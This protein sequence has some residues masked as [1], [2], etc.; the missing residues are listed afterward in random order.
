M[1]H[2]LLG[3]ILNR[4]GSALWELCN[5]NNDFNYKD[6]KMVVTFNRKWVLIYKCIKKLSSLSSGTQQ[7]AVDAYCSMGEVVVNKFGTSVLVINS[8]GLDQPGLVS[9]WLPTARPGALMFQR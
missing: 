7:K 6:I 1:I 5:N 8:L 9:K 4:N 2:T 3:S